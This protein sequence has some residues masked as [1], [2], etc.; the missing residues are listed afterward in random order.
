MG[1]AELREKLEAAR[2]T[3]EYRLEKTLL[4]VAEEVCQLIESQG[5]TRSELAQRLAV[6]PA[7][8]TKL[9][10]GNP[11]LT[12]ESLLKLSDALG[13]T[14]D[15]HFT[16]KLTVAQSVA[17]ALALGPGILPTLL[18]STWATGAASL[19]YAISGLL[20]PES[21]NLVV[22]ALTPVRGIQPSRAYTVVES[23]TKI[24][25]VDQPKEVRD[26]LPLAA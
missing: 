7:Y 14:L 18:E 5:L 17:T 15:I 26:E 1:A 8:I 11:N 2:N 23:S 13:Q 10:N 20:I 25:A 4:E 19:P 3:F 16:P 24:I 9:L 21:P 6:T 12:I 22:T